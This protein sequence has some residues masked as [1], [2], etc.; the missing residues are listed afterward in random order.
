MKRKPLS[1]ELYSVREKAM[2]RS[3]N[4]MFLT[5]NSSAKVGWWE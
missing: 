1:R 5:E 2:G 3:R 4:R